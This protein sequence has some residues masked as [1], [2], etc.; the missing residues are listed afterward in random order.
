MKFLKNPL[1]DVKDG[2]FSNDFLENFH[3]IIFEREVIHHS[4]ITGQII[5]DAHSFCNQKVRENKNQISVIAHSYLVLNF[6]FF[7]RS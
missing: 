6:S 7:N 3:D 1:I 4:H 5:R 2:I